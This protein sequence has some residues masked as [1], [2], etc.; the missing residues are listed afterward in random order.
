M[1]D[2][3]TLSL[4]SHFVSLSL[5]E[6]LSTLTLS[7]CVDGWASILLDWQVLWLLLLLLFFVCVCVCVCVCD[8]CLKEE[9]GMTEVGYGSWFSQV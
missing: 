1:L 9:V 2:F 6:L 8:R 7:L 5:Y 3:S 4:S